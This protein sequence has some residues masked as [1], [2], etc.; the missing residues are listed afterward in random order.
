MGFSCGA[1]AKCGLMNGWRFSGGKTTASRPRLRRVRRLAREGQETGVAGGSP[2]SHGR[3]YEKRFPVPKEAFCEILHPAVAAAM[4]L[5][6]PGPI[7][8]GGLGHGGVM[9]MRLKC[10]AKID[11]RRRRSR[12]SKPRLPRS[13]ARG[14]GMTEIWVKSSLPTLTVETTRSSAPKIRPARMSLS[15]S[16]IE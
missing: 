5:T 1:D 6:D 11:Q 10:R 9:K 3:A 8:P 15:A 12:I 14:S 2:A 16:V 13:A 4:P 7:K